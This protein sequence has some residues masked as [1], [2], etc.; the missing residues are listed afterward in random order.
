M[1]KKILF[2]TSATPACDHAARLAFDLAKRYQASI[3]VFHVMGIPTREFSMMVKDVRTGEDVQMDENYLQLVTEELTSYYAKQLEDCPDFTIDCTTGYPHREILRKARAA[4][5]DIVV[6]G[7]TGRGSE[8]TYT[9]RGITGST[10]QRVAKRARCPVLSVSRPSAAY[11]G[12]FS[13]I[14]FAT[15]FSKESDHAFKFALKVA[16]ELDSDLQLFHSLD[17][18]SMYAGKIL[19]QNEIEDK[20]LEARDRMR[21]RYV[22]LMGEFKNFDIEAWEGVPF[23]EIV[24][25]TRE[26]Q[27][28]LI[29]MAHNTREADYDR[30]RLGSTMEQVILRAGC[31][32]A[33]VNHP[34]KLPVGDE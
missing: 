16:K 21:S 19:S 24:K 18:T 3:S 4:D 22:P 9:D 28:D 11:W 15:D 27:A 12:G 20:L 32:V 7:A 31:P 14:V 26:K 8:D 10:L 29:V 6:M 13:N 25:F 2:A 34:E 1:F 17:I 30:A 33:S 23:V 5:V